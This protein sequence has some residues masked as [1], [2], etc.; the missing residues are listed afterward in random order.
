[1]MLQAWLFRI[2]TD[3]SSDLD[4]TQWA[5]SASRSLIQALCSDISSKN[6][7]FVLVCRDQE[8]HKLRVDLLKNRDR[9][10]QT[11]TIA[12]GGLDADSINDMLSYVLGPGVFSTAWLA[13]LLASKTQGNIYHVIQYLKTFR[14]DGVLFFSNDH[15]RWQ[16]D[17]VKAE[18]RTLSADDLLHKHVIAQDSGMTSI[19]EL[20]ACIGYRFDIKLLNVIVTAHC[21]NSISENMHALLVLACRKGLIIELSNN[22]YMF[23]HNK[24]QKCCYDLIHSNG[25]REAFHLNIGNILYDKIKQAGSA[26]D[27]MVFLAT[28]HMNEGSSLIANPEQRVELASLNLHAGQRSIAM[29]DCDRAAQYFRKGIHSLSFESAWTDNYDLNVKLHKLLAFTALHTQKFEETDTVI[30]EIMDHAGTLVDSL[31]AAY[32]MM[33]S[34]AARG[35]YETGVNFALEVLDMIQFRFNSAPNQLEIAVEAVSTRRLIRIHNDGLQLRTSQNLEPSLNATMKVLSFL[36]LFAYYADHRQRLFSMACMKMVQLSCRKGL[37]TSSA[38]GFIWYGVL[39]ARIGNANIAHKFCSLGRSLLTRM[40]LSEVDAP[41][42][43]VANALVNHQRVPL[44]EVYK[45]F[46]QT[47]KASLHFGDT[48]M[49]ILSA[50]GQISTAFYSGHIHLEQID[51]DSRFAVQCMR[52]TR[53]TDQLRLALPILQAIICL[54]GKSQDPGKLSGSVMTAERMTEEA[55]SDIDAIGLELVI[56]LRLLLAV[57]FEKWNLVR[58]LTGIATSKRKVDIPHWSHYYNSFITGIGCWSLYRRTRQRRYFRQASRITRV[59]Q[60]LADL[61]RPGCQRK[62]LLLK[63]EE[64]SLSAGCRIGDLLDSY[65]KAIGILSVREESLIDEALANE[66]S[67]SL[68]VELN[69]KPAARRCALRAIDCY[70]RWGATA[71][72]RW[73]ETKFYDLLFEPELDRMIESENTVSGRGDVIPSRSTST[74]NSGSSWNVLNSLDLQGSNVGPM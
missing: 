51:E 50:L 23:S 1:M 3:F 40:K 41:S 58:R 67:V 70:A 34:L 44:V 72:V 37:A 7:L 43:V 21:E 2:I 46:Q 18:L 16:W 66:R 25:E 59:F 49:T 29:A 4:D 26:S 32:I 71:K 10:L 64:A 20:A 69:D 65:A 8:Y 35:K 11:S 5:D 48:R 53:C 12:V 61:K 31:D 52:E 57:C 28:D 27:T 19:L 13:Q 22:E 55:K 39:H 45:S 17:E 30:F 15:L 14:D 42:L 62:Y 9:Y 73:L 54:Q 6:V 24:A 56:G 47:F 68:L 63:A 36:T 38:D 33:E 60:K 74:V